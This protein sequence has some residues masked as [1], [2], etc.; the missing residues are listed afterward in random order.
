MLK[1]NKIY[2][3]V[4]STIDSCR[5]PDQLEIARNLMGQYFDQYGFDQYLQDLWNIQNFKIGDFENHLKQISD[6]S[7]KENQ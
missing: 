4:I 3:K 7:N 5:L 1:D 2:N 6:V